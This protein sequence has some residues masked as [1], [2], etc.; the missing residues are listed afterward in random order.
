MASDTQSQLLQLCTDGNLPA[1]KDL[2]T[3]QELNPNEVKDPS[4]LTL[5]HLACQHGYL[6]IVQYL[7]RNQ[8]YNPE[9]TTPNGHT[10][11]HTACKSGHLH[12]VKCLITDHKCNPHSTDSDGYTPL[13]AA[14]ESGS[15]ETVK[16]LITE[17]R[18][19][20]QVSDSNS[21]TPL[22]YASESGHL[23][24]VQ[25]LITEF[26]CDSQ[27][28]NSR[29]SI[30]LHF[31]CRGGQIDVAR[32]L[33]DEH[34]CDPNSTNRFGN[35]SVSL[36]C[37]SGYLALVKY[38]IAVHGCNPQIANSD[39]LTPLH[40]ACLNGYL[41]ITRYLISDCNCNPQCS[42]KNGNTPL[43]CACQNGHLEVAKYLSTECKCNPKHANVNGSTLLHLAASNGH[44]AV[45]KY[46]ITQHNC[47]PECSNTNG[48]TPLHQACYSGHLHIVKYLTHEQNCGC[49]PEARV[50]ANMVRDKLGFPPHTLLEKFESVLNTDGITPLHAACEGGHIDIVKY[51]ID[52]C[53]CNPSHSTSNGLT[54]IDVAQ[55]LEHENIVSYFKNEC[56]YNFNFGL[57][58][59]NAIHCLFASSS[60][61]QMLSKTISHLLNDPSFNLNDI[62][63]APLEL[64]CITGNLGAVKFFITALNYS[65]SVGLLGFTPLHTA[66]IMGHLEIA[67]YLVTECK[68]DTENVVE[69]TSYQQTSLMPT[70]L[71]TATAIRHLEIVR[72][73]VGKQKS[74][75]ECNENGV[76]SVYLA[77]MLGLLSGIK[78]L[79]SKCSQD[80][81]G[82]LFVA[83][84][85]GHLDIVRYLI[86]E[87]A[88]NPHFVTTSGITPLHLACTGI[89]HLSKNA[90]EDSTF[91]SAVSTASKK[92]SILLHIWHIIMFSVT[93]LAQIF[94]KFI[95]ENF[96]RKSTGH[97]ITADA[98]SAIHVSRSS[99]Q[100]HANFDQQYLDI[101]KYLITE[102]KCNPQCKDKEG[103]T[104]LHYA[105]AGGQLE[106]VQYFHKEK[107]S[108]LV[109]TA[110]S[111]DTPFHSACKYNQVEV[112]QFLLSTGECDPLA[113]NTEGLTPVEIAPSS[114]ISALL[115][116]FCKG[117]Y[118]LESVVKVFVL[119]D[120]MAGKSTLVQ[121]IQGNT[122]FLSSLIG[123]FQKV[124]GVRQQTAGID[125]FSFS[126][127][128]FGNVVIYDFAGQRE[129]FTSHAAFLQNSL[130]VP[131]VF[132]LVTNITDHE[133]SICQSVQYWM[134]FIQECCAHSRAKPCI[135]IVG[136]HAD[137][138][139][140]GAVEQ[141]LK[142][143]ENCFPEH[144]NQLEGVVCLDCTRPS[145]PDLDLLRHHLKESCNFIRESTEK[146][147][148]RCYVLHKYVHKEYINM[149]IHGNK[150]KNISK[151]LKDN[152]YML[153]ST[154]T[155]LLPLF[156]TLHDRGQILFLRN[157]HS[158]DNSWV[159]TNITAILEIVV[160]SIFA[161]HDFPQHIAPGSTGIVPKSRIS[162]VFPDLDIDMVIGFLEHFEFCHRVEPDWVRI[163]QS[164][165]EASDGEYYL[166]PALVTSER[167]PNHVLQGIHDGN[168][169]CGWCMHST[170]EHQFFTTRFLHVLLLR[171][172]F[173]FAV[174]QDN[175][176]PTASEV[177][178][179]ALKRS[180]AMWKSGITWH[181]THGISTH[182]EVTDLKTVILIMSCIKGREV[183]C[184]KLRTQLISVI[185][186]ARKE[187]CPRVDVEECIMEVGN[188]RVAE[189]VQKS[190]S[191][192]NK[193]SLKYISD[194]IS[195][196]D[197]KDH[198]DLLLVNPDGSPG[199]RISELLY[200]EPYTL[201]T[202]DLVTKMFSE[203]NSTLIL[204]DVFLSELAGCLHPYNNILAL[205]FMTQPKL[206]NEK[207][208]KDVYSL[209]SLDEMSKQLRCVH[210]LE[211]WMEQQESPAT[212]KKLRQELNKYSIYCGRNPLDL[213]CKSYI[214]KYTFNC[215]AAGMQAYM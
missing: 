119:G 102:H 116:H 76:S 162:E 30:A 46:L 208:K 118:P 85:F 111:G 148:Q 71:S 82:L 1:L 95:S 16:Y 43:H 19:D 188:D 145:S 3:K 182:F 107:L 215:M 63:F 171:L 106:I 117:K 180:C 160:G 52:V 86:D 26:N 29:G 64:A 213:V 7:I 55:I 193:F 54:A 36:A 167:I 212:Y 199:K 5:L 104:L 128:D 120:S 169:C 88:C 69:T 195:T 60:V 139:D 38:L 151:D 70:P 99:V 35:T 65:P 92:Y 150:L 32:Y 31:A 112:V 34:C 12:I 2:I 51:L 159:I 122:G 25:C 115:D 66:C 173:L 185:L 189:T 73:L 201:L 134:S 200:F 10:P 61:S 131:G 87:C 130:C 14:S 154:S 105:C 125:S 153:P 13:H 209:D 198:Q 80:F 22:H 186:K 158:L 210:I 163:I 42:A 20:P 211:A 176:I 110:H 53:N 142:I 84:C 181:D 4:G 96:N 175:V 48:F 6:D 21:S 121:A 214:R 206:L 138:L 93:L 202:S 174:P 126:S 140:K 157:K 11:L 27:T 114:E 196:R 39:G 18:C 8:K 75:S 58:L 136:S 155:E 97:D 79:L 62:Y 164:K 90:L 137:Q 109:H 59:T 177:E 15:I 149:G 207:L 156:Q 166:F 94:S 184:V 205:V 78:Y 168:Y 132:I 45:V 165:H 191:Q 203:E 103:Q 194:R 123:R 113:K 44:L 28:S 143:I 40:Y 127:S 100:Q 89:Q 67:R 74:T 187:F 178:T 179:P 47:N 144:S 37:L 9:T 129:F 133:N 204:S 124:E 23:D 72:L 108:D 56:N 190:P 146:I 83:C 152:P 41:D 68:C 170:G 161:P 17:H 141:A 81:P 183:H 197:A 135:I 50:P 57:M 91:E 98:L 33:I 192:S 24:I 101:V 77:C 172:A 49:E 147:D